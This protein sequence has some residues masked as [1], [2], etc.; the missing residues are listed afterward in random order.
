MT[1]EISIPNNLPDNVASRLVEFIQGAR[2]ILGTDL[3]SIV[4]YGSAAEGKL[5]AT[6]DVNLILVLSKFDQTKAKDLGKPFQ[7]AHAAI[8]LKAMYLLDSEISQAAEAF[9]NKFTDIF[10]R[11]KVV[12]GTDP[13]A[14]ISISRGAK[15]TRLK[16]VLLNL[17]LRLRETLISD[18]QYE[19]QL[20]LAIADSAG[21]IRSS[22]ATIL[23]LEGKSTNSPKEAL[24]Q[25]VIS[26]PGN[27]WKAI[28]ESISQAR[29]TQE[30][31]GQAEYVIINLIELLK[32]MFERV[33]KL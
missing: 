26:F 14:N 6:S 5:R 18:F 12:Y 27:Q 4:L 21:P 3:V 31:S 22:A 28:L 2:S 23:E 33:N 25:L 8:D 15:I 19:S 32:L 7:V 11:H 16:Q 24:E 1:G 30:L 17:M 20:V 13:F 29:E 9:A 10:H